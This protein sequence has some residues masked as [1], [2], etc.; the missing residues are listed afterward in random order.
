M[1]GHC[2]HGTQVTVRLATRAVPRRDERFR[3]GA[4]SPAKMDP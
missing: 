3:H 4:S 2:S 1:F